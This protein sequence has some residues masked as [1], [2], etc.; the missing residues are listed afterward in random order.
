MKRAAPMTGPSVVLALLIAALVPAAPAAALETVATFAADCTTAKTV[1]Q[2]GDTLCTKVSNVAPGDLNNIFLVLVVAPLSVD[3]QTI[4]SPAP[5]PG[6]TL[7]TTDGQTFLHTL[8]TSG[9]QAGKGRWRAETRP[10]SEEHT[11]ELQSQ[12]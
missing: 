10:R 2:L 9:L 6:S 3:S 1:F 4:G 8:A 11:S 7:V 5:G 12:R